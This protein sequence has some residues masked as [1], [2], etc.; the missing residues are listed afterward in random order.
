[1]KYICDN[2]TLVWSPMDKVTEGQMDAARKYVATAAKD[3][4]DARSL[5]LMLGLIKE[6]Q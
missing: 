6:V 2:D 3:T 1:M 4:E 5:M